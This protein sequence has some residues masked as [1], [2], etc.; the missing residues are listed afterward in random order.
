MA[1]RPRLLLLLGGP[2]HLAQ[3][4]PL[5]GVGVPLVA[6]VLLGAAG[7][8]AES[9]PPAG[10]SSTPTLGQAIRPSNP[11][12]LALSEHLRRVGALFYGAWWCPACFKQKNLFGQEAGNRLPYVECDKTEAGRERCRAADIKAYPTWE[13]NGRRVEGV[14]TLE[15]LKA[16]S[17]F[18]PGG[19]SGATNPAGPGATGTTGTI[20]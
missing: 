9:A 1:V 6:A 10:H 8:R 13:L 15:E 5:L 18:N 2:L 7:V 20:R 11:D 4:R 3:R 17:G 14:Q 12:Q 19:A 16:W